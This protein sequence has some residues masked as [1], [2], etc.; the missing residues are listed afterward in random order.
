MPG[1]LQSRA[2]P[3]DRRAIAS[4][5]LAARQADQD[6]VAPLPIQFI[7]CIHCWALSLIWLWCSLVVFS[8]KRW[9]VG[10]APPIKSTTIEV[11]NVNAFALGI[12]GLRAQMQ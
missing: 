6:Q 5:G 1:S 8:R 3:I 4:S 2:E 11:V 7:Q 9:T 10:N 12:A